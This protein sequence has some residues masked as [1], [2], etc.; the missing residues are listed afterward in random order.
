MSAALPILMRS[1][2][3]TTMAKEYELAIARAE[4]ENWGYK[5]LLTHLFEMEASERLQ[6]K[7]ERLLKESNLPGGKTLASLEE[8]TLPDKI[9]RQ[10]PTL[11]DA[12]FVRRGDNLLCF[13][14]AGRGKT[15]FV[16]AVAREWICRHQ[17]Q[18]LFIPAFKLE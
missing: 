3:L 17:L 16:S 7:V 12:D 6:R 1:M 14:L 13:G 10:L 18:V 2:R 5:R 11:L 9:R 8:K 4:A 15:H